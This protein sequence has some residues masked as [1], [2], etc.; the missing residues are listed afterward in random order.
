M[1]QTMS[2]LDVITV[3]EL[4]VFAYHGVMPEENV[5]GQK[6]CVSVSMYTDIAEAGRRDDID[7]TVN[8]A[9][10]CEDIK[11]FVE[12]NTFRLIESVAQKLADML[13]KK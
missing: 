4:E 6:F 1:C 5:V 3:D 10:V 9:G 13:L 11:N 12:G 8:Y 7:M 2:K